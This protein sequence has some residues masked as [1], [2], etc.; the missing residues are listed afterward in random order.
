MGKS[1]KYLLGIDLG[2]TKILT[3]LY[4]RNYKM[5]AEYKSKM[6]SSK[7]EKNF[8][9]TLEEAWESVSDDAKIS[10]KELG[11]IG[12]GVPGMVDT[13]HGYVTFCPNISFLKNY[14]LGAKIKKMLK[15]NALIENDVNTGLFGEYQF[16]AAK[17]YHNVV[18]IFLGTG[19]G[20]AMILDGKLYRGTC[21]AAGEIGHIFLNV[22]SALSDNPSP[23]TLEGLTGRLTI[24]SEATR[25]IARQRAK[26]LYKI[27]DGA[28]IRKIKSNAIAKA[29]REGDDEL[30]DLIRYK[31]RILGIAMANLANILNPELFVLGGG[32]ME[33]IGPLI[34]RESSETLHRYA[35]KPVAKCVHVTEAKLKDYAVTMGAARLAELTFSKG[36]L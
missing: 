1:K 33:A 23:A 11:V 19:V 14:P 35:L 18:G 15:R 20:G 13:A 3:V 21:G 29:I 24:A 17:G 4:D 16:G 9:K 25:L 31:A 6:D 5:I 34:L 10:A 32:L 28:D 26:N 8:I 27:V 2:G 7:G 30:R 22:E 12:M 36:E